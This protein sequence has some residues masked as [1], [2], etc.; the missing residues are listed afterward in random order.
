VRF[1]SCIAFAL[2]Q[3]QLASSDVTFVFTTVYHGRFTNTQNRYVKAS[4]LVTAGVTDDREAHPCPV[5]LDRDDQDDGSDDVGSGT[6]AKCAQSFCFECYKKVWQQPCPTCRNPLN[7][8]DVERIRLLKAMV[9]GRTAGR[10]TGYAMH[11]LAATLGFTPEGMRWRVKSAA[12]GCRRAQFVLAGYFLTAQFKLNP[13]LCAAIVALSEA[14]QE[15][16][17]RQEFLK[18]ADWMFLARDNN[19]PHAERMIEMARKHICSRVEISG[20]TKAARLNG[21]QGFITSTLITESQS[22]SGTAAERVAVLLDGEPKPVLVREV[23][24]CLARRAH[25]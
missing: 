8:P 7:L 20:L 21:R 14:E 6:C 25:R 19:H 1:V 12:L 18:A 15:K 10:H 4:A 11:L 3:L 17:L 5:C 13:A 16:A 24:L 22:P 2:L 9:S 23:N